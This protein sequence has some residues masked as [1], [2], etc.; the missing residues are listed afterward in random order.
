MSISDRTL[1]ALAAEHGTPLL[2]LDGGEI[3]ARYRALA[4]ALPNVALHYAIKAL[5][6]DAVVRALWHEGAGFDVASAGEIGVLR[7]EGVDPRRCIHTHPIKKPADIKAALRFGCTT[8]VVDNLTEID[9]FVPF[10]HRVA[11]LLRLSFRSPDAVVDLSRKFG[12][13]L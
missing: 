4:A 1:R 8:F 5:P 12:C 9:K 11:L 13:S 6:H 2:V 10:R 7:R 3:R